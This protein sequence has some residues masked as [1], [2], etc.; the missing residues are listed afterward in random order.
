MANNDVN[1][2]AQ[3]YANSHCDCVQLITFSFTNTTSDEF[4]ISFSNGTDFQLSVHAKPGPSSIQIP[5]G[6]YS[7]SVSVIGSSNQHHIYIGSQSAVTGS[8]AN[9]NNVNVSSSTP[10][11]NKIGMY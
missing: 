10:G 5:V 11:E 7:I 8:F 6:T 3:N 4:G 2:N 9:F 1:Q